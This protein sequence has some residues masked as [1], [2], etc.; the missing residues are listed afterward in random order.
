[1]EHWT[2]S[3]LNGSGAHPRYA[4]FLRVGSMS[5]G[6][7]RLRAGSSDPQSPHAQDELYLVLEGRAVLESGAERIGVEPGS[8]CFVERERPHRFVDIAEDLVVV[9]FFAPEES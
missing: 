4:E 7:Y 6:V 8:L 9:V 3:Q 5:A 1:M 2:L